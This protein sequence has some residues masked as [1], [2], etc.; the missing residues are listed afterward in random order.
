MEPLRLITRAAFEKLPM[1][2]KYT[3]Y[4][5]A[6]N[7]SATIRDL[8]TEMD[9]LKSQLTSLPPPT[10]NSPTVEQL[11]RV[12]SPNAP[13][14]LPHHTD[15]YSCLTLSDSM[16]TFVSPRDIAQ[17]SAVLSWAGAKAADIKKNVAEL[18]VAGK[19]VQTVI[20]NV[21]VNDIGSQL[22]EGHCDAQQVADET[23]DCA[24]F[25]QTKLEPKSI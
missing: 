16:W 20:L 17:N 23:L 4:C 21:G 10:T 22:R 6:L 11:K 18:E 24:N 5:N 3:L 1:E 14:R 25:L 8:R 7:F 19:S 2:D 9:E 12:I 13:K 15:D